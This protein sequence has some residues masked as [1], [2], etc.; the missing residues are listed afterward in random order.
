MDEDWD[1]AEKAKALEQLLSHCS[2]LAVSPEKAIIQRKNE[3]KALKRRYEKPLSLLTTF[4]MK[5][6][7]LE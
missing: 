7:F 3:V 2:S 6:G 4:W 5:G 1:L